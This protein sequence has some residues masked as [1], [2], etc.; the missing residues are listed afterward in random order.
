MGLLVERL[1]TEG[2]ERLLTSWVRDIGG[3]ERFY[4]GLG[5][6]LTGDIDEGEHVGE[7]RLR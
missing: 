4:L 6:R 5:F 3:P 2:H 1:R 7:L